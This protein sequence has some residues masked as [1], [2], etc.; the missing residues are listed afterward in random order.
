MAK[1]IY[2]ALTSLDLYVEDAAGGLAWAVYSRTLDAVAT[3]KTRLERE[4][5]PET[6]RELKARSGRDL[7]IGGAELAGRDLEAGLVDEIHLLAAPVLVGGGKPALP[8]RGDR[9]DLALLDEHGSR[10]EPR[11][12]ATPFAGDCARTR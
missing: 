6:V 9:I 3:P 5:T 2:A 11:T 1:L 4:F 8:Q 10:T 7:S 12:A